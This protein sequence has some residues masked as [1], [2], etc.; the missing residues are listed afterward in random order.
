MI[1]FSRITVARVTPL[2]PITAP[3]RCPSRGRRWN[4]T[5]KRTQRWIVVAGELR[6]STLAGKAPNSEVV[7]MNASRVTP[8]ELATTIAGPSPA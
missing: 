7:S 3:E 5:W 4:W 1:M 8:V 6:T 2:S